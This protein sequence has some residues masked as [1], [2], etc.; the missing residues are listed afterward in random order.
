MSLS[1]RPPSDQVQP[2]AKSVARRNGKVCATNFV[3]DASFGLRSR[4]E[5]VVTSLE[6]LHSRL[7]KFLQCYVARQ[8]SVLQKLLF[9]RSS[10]A[11]WPSGSWHA[12]GEYPPRLNN[13]IYVEADQKHHVQ[14]GLLCQ[15][16]YSFACRHCKR[17]RP[18]AATHRCSRASTSY[19]A[20]TR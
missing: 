10:K 16:G 5:D 7:L 12:S 9:V 17:A 20:T 8:D 3:L 1:L 14:L 19:R 18:N 2:D 4:L 6:T 15:G 11:I 13:S